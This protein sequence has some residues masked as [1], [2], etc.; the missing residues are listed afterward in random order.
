[1]GCVNRVSVV[2]PFEW[3]E[4]DILTGVRKA[5][6]PTL[7]AQTR[8]SRGHLLCSSERRDCGNH[9]QQSTVIDIH[10]SALISPED[11]EMSFTQDSESIGNESIS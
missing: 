9:S 2:G 1:M 6:S 7:T 5:D 11:R 3:E 10:W 8:G 4:G